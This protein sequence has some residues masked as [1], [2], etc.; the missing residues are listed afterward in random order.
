M[1]LGPFKIIPAFAGLTKGMDLQ[2]KRAVA[3]QAATIASVLCAF[4]VIAG[5]ALLNKYRISIDAVR[6]TGGLVLLLAALNAIFT[7]G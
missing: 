7:K 5:T 4:V 1:L 3:I 6:I 2:F